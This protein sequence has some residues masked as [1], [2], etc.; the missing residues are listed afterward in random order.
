MT[1]EMTKRRQQCISNA[2]TNWQN[3]LIG[4]YHWWEKERYSKEYILA[5][6]EFFKKLK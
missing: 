3:K 5:Q 6:I 2:I 4:L 1:K